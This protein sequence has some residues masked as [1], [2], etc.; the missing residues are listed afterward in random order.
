[1]N[2]LETLWTE[3]ANHFDNTGG[4]DYANRFEKIAKSLQ[5]TIPHHS[6]ETAETL[7]R[8]D[9]WTTRFSSLATYLFNSNR[10]TYLSSPDATPYLGG[11]MKR[12][13]RGSSMPWSGSACGRCGVMGELRILSQGQV[14]SPCHKVERAEG[15]KQ[16][17]VGVVFHNAS[18]SYVFG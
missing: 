7:T 11:S 13:A 15:V 17:Q 14:S 18:L 1:M 16:F 6:P 3:F 2:V 5:P 4:I 10:A 8:L 9:T 12:C